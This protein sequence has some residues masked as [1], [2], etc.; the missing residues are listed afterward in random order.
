MPLEEAITPKNYII[1]MG[2]ALFVIKTT[3]EE[4]LLEH[5]RDKNTSNEAWDT[6]TSLFLKKNDLRG[7]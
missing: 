3:I 6:L 1:K 2:K 4:Q 7:F 5:I